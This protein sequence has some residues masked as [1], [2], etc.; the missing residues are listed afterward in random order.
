MPISFNMNEAKTRISGAR[1]GYTGNDGVIPGFTCCCC[2]WRCST[3]RWTKEPIK[4]PSVNF[5]KSR[6]LP[7]VLIGNSDT[8]ENTKV[9]KTVVSG[10][11]VIPSL[12]KIPCPTAETSEANVLIDGFRFTLLD[13][14]LNQGEIIF[15]YRACVSSL[16]RREKTLSEKR[17]D[18]AYE[19]ET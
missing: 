5:A 10:R 18:H 14:I 3:C 8:A 1:T 13:S 4:A 11:P 12:V 16:R 7:A 19:Q 6:K 9:R 2:C 17:H 15:R